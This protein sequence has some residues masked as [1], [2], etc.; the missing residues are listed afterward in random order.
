[1]KLYIDTSSIIFALRNKRDLLELA[2]LEGYQPVV[3]IGVKRE[4][5]RIA[6]KAASMSKFAGL[7]LKEIDAYASQ[8]RLIVEA[9]SE[10]PD[11]W[12]LSLPEGSVVLTNDMKLKHMLKEKG[13][14]VKSIGRDGRM[15]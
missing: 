4:L 9:N 10:R 6:E 2:A 14:K 7:A 11:N 3:S 12:L 8:G 5:E 15:R 1:M 13:I